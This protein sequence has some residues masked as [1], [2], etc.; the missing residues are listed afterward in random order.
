MSSYAAPTASQGSDEPTSIVPLG[1]LFAL[2]MPGIGLILGIIAATRRNRAARHHGPWIIAA[3]AAATL[4]WG[5]AFYQIYNAEVHKLQTQQD[6]QAQQNDAQF[7][8]AIRAVQQRFDRERTANEAK[9]ERERRT[10][11]EQF[12]RGR[13]AS[14][15][16]VERQ[17]R[18]G[19]ARVGQLTAPAGR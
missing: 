15:E 1:Y 8:Q 11:E 3:S 10:T 13:H 19:E 9:F 6:Q 14:E 12:N 7:N 4:V 17:A 2:I 18:E 16:A 5:L